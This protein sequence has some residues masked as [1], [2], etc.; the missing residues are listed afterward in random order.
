[1]AITGRPAKYDNLEDM[2]SKI[3]SYFELGEIPTMA[4]LAGHLGFASRFS[5][6]D[7]EGK[8]EFSHLIKRARNE[9]EKFWEQRLASQSC[10]GAIFWLKNHGKYSDKQEIEHSGDIFKAFSGM[11]EDEL[12]AKAGVDKPKL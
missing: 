6:N 7:Y 9:I 5:L 12:Y 1:M 11:S 8:E 4:G 10:T 3:E 2:Q